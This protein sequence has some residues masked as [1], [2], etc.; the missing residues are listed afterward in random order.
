[1]ALGG[2]MMSK[3]TG[4]PVQK[5]KKDSEGKGYA[6]PFRVEREKRS[7]TPTARWGGKKK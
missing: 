7:K 2:K 3:G 5:G 4:E 1:M 6:D